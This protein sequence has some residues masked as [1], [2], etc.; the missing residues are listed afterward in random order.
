MSVAVV[1]IAPVIASAATHCKDT[2][3]L[4]IPTKPVHL[5]APS[6]CHGGVSHTLMAYIIFGIATAMYSCLI[7]HKLTPLATL[8]SLR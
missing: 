2:N 8:A 3:L 5:F 6:H 7:N 4:T 1:C